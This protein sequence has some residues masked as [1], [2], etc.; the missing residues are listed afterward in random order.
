MALIKET[1]KQPIKAMLYQ[2]RDELDQDASIEK[3]ASLMTDAVDAYIRSATVVVI[4]TSVNGGAVT[5]T[6]SIQ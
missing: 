3:Y 6:G 1:L 2:L 5:G 4:G